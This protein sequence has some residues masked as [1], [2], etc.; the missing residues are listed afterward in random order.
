CMRAGLRPLAC[1]CHPLTQITNVSLPCGHLSEP[2]SDLEE[3]HEAD[4]CQHLAAKAKAPERGPA[5]N[6]ADH[7][8]EVL[9]EEPGDEAERQEDRGYDGELLADCVLPV[10]RDGEVDLQRAVYQ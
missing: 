6:V 1:P 7:V 2:L 4:E 9:A 3:D 10:G 8:A 5:R